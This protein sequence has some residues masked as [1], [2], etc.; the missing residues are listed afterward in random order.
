MNEMN[1]CFLPIAKAHHYTTRSK[2]NQN[3]FPDSVNTNCAKNSIKFY[4]VQLRNL[5]FAEIKSFFF[6]VLKRN[7]ERFC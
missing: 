2:S 4:G 5:I 1:E 6:T 3:Y 7:I